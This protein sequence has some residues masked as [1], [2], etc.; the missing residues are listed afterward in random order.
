M[1]FVFSVVG[2][3]VDKPFAIDQME[4]GCPNIFAVMT[5]LGRCPNFNASV[6][7]DVQNC[8]GFADVD[9]SVVAAFAK[10]IGAFMKNHPRIGGWSGDYRVKNHNFFLVVLKVD[11]L[12]LAKRLSS[13]Y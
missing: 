2:G 10:I 5:A 4:F 1:V 13:N 11:R 12:F 6:F 3:V 7:A 8:A 9:C